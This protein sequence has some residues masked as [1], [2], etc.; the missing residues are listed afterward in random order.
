MEIIIEKIKIVDFSRNDINRK[1]AI[2]NDCNNNTYLHYDL[3]LNFSNTLKWF[4]N[5]DNSKRLDCTILYENEIC[6]FIGLLNMDEKNKKAEF[7]ICIDYLFSGKN[8]GTVAS[9]K[10]IEFV[11]N[12]YNLNKI[13]LYTEIENKK[14]QHLFE[15]IGFIQE[16][17][18]VDD[19]I[20]NGKKVSRYEYGLFKKH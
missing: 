17:K 2:I 6:G 12:K 13:Y 11:F 7:Y 3:P 16:G 20:Y 1:I 5:K 18:L 10:F 4:E 19:L 15:K 9:S 8:I 14:A